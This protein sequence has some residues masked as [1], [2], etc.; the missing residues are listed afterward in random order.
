MNDTMM[1]HVS[2]LIMVGKTN[3]PMLVMFAQVLLY[4]HLSSCKLVTAD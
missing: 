1:L 4:N 3:A 2:D